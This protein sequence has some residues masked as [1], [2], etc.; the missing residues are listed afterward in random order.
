VVEGKAGLTHHP[1]EVKQ[2]RKE[3]NM[4]AMQKRFNEMRE[5][6]EQKP[7]PNPQWESYSL[8]QVL[9]EINAVLVLTRWNKENSTWKAEIVGAEFKGDWESSARNT[10]FGVGHWPEA[11]VKDLEMRVRGQYLMLN[12][13]NG[14]GQNYRL[15]DVFEPTTQL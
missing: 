4:N 1:L 6:A 11:A 3:S 9:D 14:L 7:Q 15:P 8:I 5:R 2:D 10:Y 12:S 13:H